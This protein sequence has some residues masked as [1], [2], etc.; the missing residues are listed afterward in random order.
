ML[1]ETQVYLSQ[2]SCS[3]ILISSLSK[4]YS[5][6]LKEL[7]TLADIGYGA[8]GRDLRKGFCFCFS[9]SKKNML[10]SSIDALERLRMINPQ[11]KPK[12]ERQMASLAACISCNWNTENT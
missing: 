10:L 8:S 11:L 5:L 4:L 2:K 1:A 9:S 6:F 12:C 3:C 7:K